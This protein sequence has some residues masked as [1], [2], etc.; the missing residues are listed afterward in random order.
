MQ[1]VIVLMEGI[2]DIDHQQHMTTILDTAL[3]AAAR[4]WR[5]LPVHW[6]K[7]P[8]ICSCP[9]GARCN[10][11]A[12]H[13]LISDW[14]RMAST[15]GAD[16]YE[17]W[18]RWPKANLG[19]A[20]GYESGIFTVDIDPDHG[21]DI[22]LAEL[23]AEHGPLPLTRRHRTGSGGDHYLFE[24]PAFDVISKG[25]TFG[26]G[27]DTRGAG[28]FIVAPPSVSAKGLYAVTDDLD[29]LPAPEWMLAVLQPLSAH[30]GG[31]QDGTPV[32]GEPVDQAAV[33]AHV[34]ELLQVMLCDGQKRFRHFWR[35]I[36]AARR[37]GYTQGQAVTLAAPWC[38]MTG[39]FTGRVEKQA[40]A[41]WG[42]LEAE[43]QARQFPGPATGR[44]RAAASPAAEDPARFTGPP[45][46][47][48]DWGRRF[49][50]QVT[51]MRHVH[52]IGWHIWDGKRWREDDMALATMAM[53]DLIRGS[54]AELATIPSGDA[55]NALK[56]LAMM[57]RA[58]SVSGALTLAA[59]RPGTAVAARQVDAQPHLL[60]VAN[61][62][63][64]LTSMTLRDHDPQQLLTK[65]CRGACR[66]DEG[67][68]RW[69][70]FIAEILPDPDVRAFVQRLMGVAAYGAVIEHVLAVLW[71]R[72]R[73]GKSTFIEAVMH[74]LG[75]YALQAD[76][77]LL[78]SGASDRHSTER[79]DL[80]GKRLAI[81]MET[82]KG[83]QVDAAMAK[84]LTGGDTITARR[85]RK[86]NIS[87]A[88]SHTVMLVSN[89]KPV[90]PGDDDALWKRIR[91]IPFTQ[92]FLGK[93]ADKGL[94]D[95]LKSDPDAV[96]TWM[97]NGWRDYQCDGLNE[98]SAVLTA[99]KS[100]REES[101]LIGQFLAERCHI[102][103]SAY[104]LDQPGEKSSI[105]YHAWAAWCK[106]RG[107][108]SG[109]Q[110]EF[111]M[112][113]TERGLM[114]RRCNDG[115]RWLGVTLLEES[116]GSEG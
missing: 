92:Q 25:D 56:D 70:K 69:S 42:K 24:Y 49:A 22:T 74:A 44:H 102:A 38:L 75:D 115:V 3:A 61:G 23:L 88:P 99:T 62:T 113:L 104:G 71:G 15:S 33:P 7:A 10:S 39:K 78:L 18:D 52:G 95:L 36:A 6:L 20:M 109:S 48:D 87:F 30:V 28:G 116:A 114:S 13:P 94:P 100:Y 83:R 55:K 82:A 43:E 47:Q 9:A 108:D 96:I 76:A 14:A 11:I 79:A 31:G 97:A 46:T 72:G 16:I 1:H 45:R 41:V 8:G 53:S 103:E 29:P 40:A 80:Q 73:N 27:I 68:T 50:A 26:T 63:L 58:S 21:G 54:Y 91:L 60:N 67:E 81:C 5:I 107:E 32:S 90:V 19:I 64:N 51:N 85:M 110:K 77:K 57:R 35:I 4:G 112:T 86:D 34:A 59:A 105:L 2:S 98:P 89:Y 93:N 106:P 111:T 17:W 101:D 66:P 12:K 84:Q 37:A 65:V